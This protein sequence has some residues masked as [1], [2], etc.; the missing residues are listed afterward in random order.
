MPIASLQLIPQ[1][2][3]HS[4]RAPVLKMG[5][6]TDSP[7]LS[8]DVSFS[9][10]ITDLISLGDPRDTSEAPTAKH[11]VIKDQH[12]AATHLIHKC[13]C[14][15]QALTDEFTV[16]VAYARSVDKLPFRHTRLCTLIE[17]TV[18]GNPVS[19]GCCRQDLDKEIQKWFGNARHRLA[20]RTRMDQLATSV[21][22]QEAGV[23]ELDVPPN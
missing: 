19:K 17:E 21:L 6:T 13:A 12:A 5:T 16:S 20:Q 14:L 22:N 18:L 7:Q 9:E 11:L 10:I 15:R 1:R 23:F 3:P 8:G 2:L 4:L